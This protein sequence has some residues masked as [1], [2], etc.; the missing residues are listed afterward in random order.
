MTQ[1]QTREIRQLFIGITRHIFL[2]RQYMTHQSFH[3]VM[4][5]NTNLHTTPPFVAVFLVAV[6]CKFNS[7]HA[8]PKVSYNSVIGFTVHSTIYDV[9]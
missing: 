4:N 8:T 3:I 1:S 9:R 2:G 6:V 7:N 5:I